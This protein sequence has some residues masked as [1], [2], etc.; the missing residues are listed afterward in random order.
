MLTH[1]YNR[2]PELPEVLQQQQRKSLPS[3]PQPRLNRNYASEPIVSATAA[4][5]SA[6]ALVVAGVAD[7]PTNPVTG[8]VAGATPAT[9]AAAA[10][11]AGAG[12]HA[13]M[14]SPPI[15][16]IRTTG[17]LQ[18]M[19][20]TASSSMTPESHQSAPS[21]ESPADDPV[22]QLQRS[23]TPAASRSRFE[24]IDARLRP[25][26]NCM[27]P[28][29]LMRRTRVTPTHTCTPDFSMPAATP[30]PPSTITTT[31]GTTKMSGKIRTRITNPESSRSRG[32]ARTGA[33]KG[34]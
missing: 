30:P 7:S 18:M 26:T 2:A 10:A 17:E 19:T 12:A 34:Y 23:W 32:R 29:R 25:S 6:P 3:N 14:G 5:P 33:N 31:T 1:C 27:A 16:A 22:Q 28:S 24:S 15:P 8:A 20:R 4:A 13:E 9:A 21:R 11:G